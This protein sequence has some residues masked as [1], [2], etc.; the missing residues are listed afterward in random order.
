MRW[1]RIVGTLSLIA[2][3]GSSTPAVCCLSM[4]V[5]GTHSCCS[6]P[7]DE[8]LTGAPCCP[9]SICATSIDRHAIEP[10]PSVLVHPAH[11]S[12]MPA[13]MLAHEPRATVL[14]RSHSLPRSHSPT[15]AALRTIVLIV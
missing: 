5:V 10:T 12:I 6:L 8:A 11:G 7:S 2:A 13:Q 14:A 15:L 1:L 4:R 9:G 3:L